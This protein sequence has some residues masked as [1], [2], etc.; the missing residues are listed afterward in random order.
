MKDRETLWL[1]RCPIEAQARA[2]LKG[3]TVSA[4]PPS[5]QLPAAGILYIV[6]KPLTQ[7]D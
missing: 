2:A 5:P 3:A 1:T 6:S 7:G 4:R